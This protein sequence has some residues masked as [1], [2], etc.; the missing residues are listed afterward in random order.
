HPVP[1]DADPIAKPRAAGSY[2]SL[3][4]HELDRWLHRYERTGH[5]SLPRTATRQA[6]LRRAEQWIVKR[7]EADG[8]WGGI[9][10]PIVYSVIALSLQGYA[11]DHPVMAAALGG[12]EGFVLDDEAGRR[13]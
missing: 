9:Q 8:C 5:W 12:I 4:F 6:A 11:L 1:G 7:Q 13:I 10:P 2:L 3:G